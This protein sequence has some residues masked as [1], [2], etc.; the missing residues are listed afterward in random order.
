MKRSLG[1][2]AMLLCLG[3]SPAALGDDREV[4]ESRAALALETLR[5]HAPDAVSLLRKAVGILVFPD[6]VEMGFGTG[7]QYGEGVL[8]IDGEAKAYYATAGAE[9]GVPAQEGPKAQVILFMTRQALIDFRNT[10]NWKVGV[11]GGVTKVQVDER[12]RVNTP[13]G[14]GPVLGFTFSDRGVLGHLD[15]AGSSINRIAR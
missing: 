1:V 15:L 5:E 9:H 13:P 8:L 10:V 12:G 3:L 2:W 11:H 14:L 7:G 4:I 6:I